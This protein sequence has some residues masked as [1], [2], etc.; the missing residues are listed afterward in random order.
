MPLC[1]VLFKIDRSTQ[2]FDPEALDGRLSTG[3]SRRE[4]L[5]GKNYLKIQYSIENIQFLN[6]SLD[7][8]GMFLDILNPIAGHRIFRQDQQDFFPHSNKMI[9]RIPG[10]ISDPCILFRQF[11]DLLQDKFGSGDANLQQLLR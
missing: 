9:D 10:Y 8:I 5:D 4:A 1:S 7:S 6:L 11:C 3:V 2:S